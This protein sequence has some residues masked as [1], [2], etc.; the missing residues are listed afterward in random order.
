MEK[1]RKY[2]NNV[3]QSLSGFL[4]PCN[5]TSRRSPPGSSPCFNPYRVFSGLATFVVSGVDAPTDRFQSLSG[6][7]RP[8]NSM[9]GMI[10]LMLGMFQSLSG[11]LRPCN[12]E[13]V[14][15][16]IGMVRRF[17][18]YRVF[19]GLATSMPHFESVEVIGFQSLSGFLRPC[20][21]IIACPE[22]VLD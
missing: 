9:S 17:N 2:W 15:I 14:N 12:L 4:R 8:C 13:P 21:D 20:N 6:F 19:S 10:L 7:L 18:P 1:A 22:R 3:F 11:F 5:D 16:V